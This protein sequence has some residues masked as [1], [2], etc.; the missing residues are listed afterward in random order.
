MSTSSSTAHSSALNRYKVLGKSIWIKDVACQN[1]CDIPE[2]CGCQ[3]H[4]VN[5]DALRAWYDEKAPGSIDQTNLQQLFDE[6]QSA[7]HQTFPLDFDRFFTGD[8]RCP[9]VFSSLLDQNQGRLIPYFYE[10]NIH[11]LYIDREVNYETLRQKLK[12]V[13]PPVEIERVIEHFERSKWKYCPLELKLPVERY[14]EDTN[15]ILPFCRKI[16]LG[17]KGATASVYWVAIQKELI[18]DEGLKN[19]LRESLHNDPEFGECYQ[20]ALK[21]YCGNKAIAYHSE[22]NAFSGL[23]SE[24]DVPIIRCLGSYTHRHGEGAQTGETYNL[25]LEFGEQDLYQYWADETNVPPVRAEEIISAWKSLFDIADA[26]HHIHNLDVR[27]GKGD[28]LRY[29]GWHADIKPDNILIVHGRFKLADFGFSRFTPAAKS[30]S[31]AAPTEII[32]GFT[33]TYGAPEVFRALRSDETLSGVPQSI[34]T[35]SF[36]CVLSV[37][38]TWIVLGFPGVLQYE[39]LRARAASNREGDK[40][41][42]RFHDGNKV[43]PDI[44][45]WHNYLRGHMRPSDTT[46]PLVLD[47]IENHMLQ[48]DPYNRLEISALCHTLKDC[49]KMAEEK[50][51]SLATHS[52]NTD[53]TVLGALLELEKEAAKERSSRTKSTP[54]QQQT[55]VLVNATSSQQVQKETRVFQKVQLIRK[56]PLGQTTNRKEILENQLKSNS[57][58]KN[59]ESFVNEPHNGAITDS[60]T[61]SQSPDLF[62]PERKG[63][64]RNPDHHPDSSSVI[65]KSMPKHSQVTKPGPF[66]EAP[67]DCN[68]GPNQIPNGYRENSETNGK[69]IATHQVEPFGRFERISKLPESSSMQYGVQNLWPTSPTRE[70]LGTSGSPASD[71]SSAVESPSNFDIGHDGLGLSRAHG[72]THDA[73]IRKNSRSS[74]KSWNTSPATDLSLVQSNFRSVPLLAVSDSGHAQYRTKHGTSDRHPHGFERPSSVAILPTNPLGPTSTSFPESTKYSGQ[75]SAEDLHYTEK[76]TVIDEYKYDSSNIARYDELPASVYGL[77]YDI[78]QKRKTLDQ[79]TPKGLRARFK[80]K[81]GMEN[82]ERDLA[83]ASTFESR[84][85]LVL[86]VD[87]GSTMCKHW[88]IAMF[89]AETL[90]KKAAGLDKDGIDLVFTVDG[91]AHNQRDMVGDAGRKRL[92]ASLNSA[93][94]EDTDNENSQTDMLHTLTNIVQVWRSKGRPATTLLVLTDGIWRRTVPN[95]FDE[96]IVNLSKETTADQ[97]TGSRPFSIQFIRF[98]EEGFERLRYLDDDLCKKCRRDIVD[99][100][101]WR[102]TVDKMFKGSIEAYHDRND[103]IEPRI[104]HFYPDLVDL[105]QSFNDNLHHDRQLTSPTNLL[106]PLSPPLSSLSRSSS[107]GSTS[108]STQRKHDSVPPVRQV[109]WNSH[110]RKTF[111]G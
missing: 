16:K 29:Y 80:V 1:Q 36:G 4:I 90:A 103:A 53:Q 50:V 107:R 52:R 94:P 99:H 32:T 102:A 109:S 76:Q 10:S 30:S 18:S 26:I 12:H 48:S 5:V 77:P 49:I 84:R 95:L 38:A 88:P 66:N 25:L 42:D 87:N 14:L 27:R 2:S 56:K 47:L 45:K 104:T 40:S 57:I 72:F 65:H 60:P 51:K 54:L 86:V 85:D 74:A 64:R 9:L 78:C 58:E 96:S 92:R 7:D 15:V 28:P 105:F 22:K 81:M 93:A 106:S 19:A 3:K 6:M 59:D 79:E 73:P 111:S 63:K 17:D 20:M 13:I 39:R 34:D 97:R 21:S 46:T 83:L 43:L 89:V 71:V 62:Q 100:C 68:R 61:Q 70:S 41:Y 82:R 98:G 44:R 91:H 33:D 75:Q 11:D 8:R 69:V 37:A 55:T 24:N 35:W 23:K 110:H 101:S 31:G 108:E 67:R